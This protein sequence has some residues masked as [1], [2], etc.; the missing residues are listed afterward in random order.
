[1]ICGCFASAGSAE[2]GLAIEEAAIRYQFDHNRSGQKEKAKVYCIVKLID[3]VRT[4]PAPALMQRF[5]ADRRLVKAR[6]GC[7]TKSDS[8]VVDRA[9][10]VQ[11][12][13]I[14]VGEVSW[15]SKTEAT[16]SGGYYEAPESAS[17]NLYHPSQGRR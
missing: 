16:I 17:S 2:D 8:L 3:G 13:V 11:G 10:G 14:S 9:S 15:M 1:M 12:L 4:E 5:V 7:D 6:S